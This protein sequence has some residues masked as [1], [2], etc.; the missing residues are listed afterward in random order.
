M[1]LRIIL[2]CLLGGVAFMSPAMGA[3]HPFWWWTSGVVV[4]AAFVPV[5]LFGPKTALGQFGVIFPVLL[6]VSV[7]TMWSEALLFIKSAADPGAL[8]FVT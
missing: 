4:T 6:L 5:A 7:L 8:R 2:Y 3:G 1:I